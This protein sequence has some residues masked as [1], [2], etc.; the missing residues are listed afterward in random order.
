MVITRSF[1]VSHFIADLHSE[2]LRHQLH[3]QWLIRMQ[4]VFQLEMQR[5]ARATVVISDCSPSAF[6]THFEAV[7]VD[8]CLDYPA[9][10]NTI[11]SVRALRS[12][13]LSLQEHDVWS[14]ANSS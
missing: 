8:G 14:A 5:I 3:S 2:H 12:R 1:Q 7:R 4:T 11:L 9:V 10:A 6:E 13:L